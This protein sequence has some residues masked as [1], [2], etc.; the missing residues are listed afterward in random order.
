M[1]KKT[2]TLVI[3]LAMTLAL[4]A[5]AC[6]RDSSSSSKPEDGTDQGSGGG[7]GEGGGDPSTVPGFD[8]TTIKLGVLTPESG[9]AA[10]IGDPL[11]NGNRAF[12]ESINAEGGLDG[13]FEVELVVKDNEYTPQETITQYNQIKDDVVA[14]QQIL[15]TAPLEALLPQI[16]KD[17]T[18]AGPA[19][20]DAPWYDEENLMPILAT[21]QIQA[22]NGVDFFINEMDGEGKNLCTLVS[23]NA[24]GDAGAEGA[25]F[26]AE[27]LGV[28]FVAQET[29]TSGQE[30]FTAQI[31]ALQKA[32]CE[33]VWLTALPTETSPI[34]KR[35]ID[36]DFA[37]Q[38]MGQSPTWVGP[39]P[40]LVGNT[41]YLADNFVVAAAGAE[42]GDESVPGMV[43][44]LEA[45]AEFAP[46]QAPDLYFAFGWLQAKA[47]SQILLKAIEAGD[48]SR[49]GIIEASN[50]TDELVFDEIV[51]VQSW[52]GP[53]DRVPG[54][55]T[56]FL[57]VTPDTT[58]EN[59][60][61]SLISDAA[62]NYVSDFVEEFEHS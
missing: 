52:G 43:D 14:F 50:S 39:L 6:G 21:Y 40:M 56:T 55:D 47:M 51:N 61:L 27:K 32:D 22:V 59:G 44:M 8:G 57:A 58:E 12:W 42:W 11:T 23:N 41:D 62:K 46:D 26:A 3:V 7:E 9:P 28:D 24:Y 45:Q 17:N 15:G 20:L 37:P 34:L 4:V 29:F 1:K 60:G 54:P 31:N 19:T 30:D 38:W 2:S 53:D 13:R 49:D 36:V 35:A 48:L 16:R 10:V 25:A 18:F 5:S 33:F